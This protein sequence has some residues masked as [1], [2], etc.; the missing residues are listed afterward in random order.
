MTESH[1]EDAVRCLEAAARQGAAVLLQRCGFGAS[2]AQE[3]AEY[4]RVSGALTEV[5]VS[6]T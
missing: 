4:V 5:L 6:I 2:G 3:I 1:E